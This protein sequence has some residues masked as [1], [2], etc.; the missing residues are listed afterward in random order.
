MPQDLNA[1][2]YYELSLWY[3]EKHMQNHAREACAKALALNPNE[4]LLTDCRRFMNTRVPRHE[5]PQDAIDRLRR[6][7]PRLL[8]DHSEAR[9]LAHKIIADYPDF[10][11]PRRVLADI[12]LRDGDVENCKASLEAALKI[13]PD[14]TQAIALM[15]RA[16]TV[17]M[18]YSAAQDHIRRALADT[19]DDPDM[20]RLQRSIEFLIALDGEEQ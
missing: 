1:S 19:P 9:K 8:M 2:Q 14:Y 10:E 20:R 17:D 5:I 12:Y 6:L 11:W 4:P 3:E 13:N 18:E 7:E 16:L 15:A